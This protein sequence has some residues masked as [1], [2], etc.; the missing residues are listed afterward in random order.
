MF[1]RYVNTLEDAASILRVLYL[2]FQKKDDTTAWLLGVID[3]SLSTM[4]PQLL[5][6]NISVILVA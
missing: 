4:N 5:C 6:A 3:G 1:E 2:Y